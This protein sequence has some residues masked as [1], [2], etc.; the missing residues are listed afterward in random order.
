MRLYYI[1]ESLR[2][3]ADNDYP[4]PLTPAE[5]GTLVAEWDRLREGEERRLQLLDDAG[6]LEN[7]RNALT[8][9]V[10]RLKAEVEWLREQAVVYHSGETWLTVENERLKK[11][12]EARERVMRREGYNLRT[13]ERE[14]DELRI[15][16]ERLRGERHIDN[17]QLARAW[18]ES[19]D[20]ERAAVVRFMRSD[21]W[22]YA[23]AC[24]E[25]GVMELAQR[26][27]R[28]EHREVK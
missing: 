4:W 20:A 15:E 11:N 23:W 9:E 24:A 17:E 18:D 27:E 14:R 10:A 2:R 26:I 21:R 12:A 25:D 22:A 8:A 28:G 19:R 5:A 7:E 16:I 13:A 6:G 3:A 1:R